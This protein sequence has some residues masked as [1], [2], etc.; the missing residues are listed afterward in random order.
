M[1]NIFLSMDMI[2]QPILRV[3]LFMENIILNIR[4]EAIANRIMHYCVNNKVQD[5]TNLKLQK[6]NLQMS[7]YIFRRIALSH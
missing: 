2:R 3:N 7:I 5:I 4:S 1:L 6:L